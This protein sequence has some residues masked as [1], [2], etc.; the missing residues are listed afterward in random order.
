MPRREAGRKPP[1][2]L[3]RAA[4]YV[5]RVPAGLPRLIVAAGVFGIALI[6]EPL[7]TGYG[8][9]GQYRPVPHGDVFDVGKEEIPAHENEQAAARTALAPASGDAGREGL[10][11]R[12]NRRRLGPGAPDGG[13]GK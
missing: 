2:I 10:R 5:R 9:D 8:R 13:T 4:P 3:D 1:T 7:K 11:S 12:G 6:M